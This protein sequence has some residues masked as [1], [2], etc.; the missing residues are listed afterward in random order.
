M[1]VKLESS[2]EYTSNQHRKT[3]CKQNGLMSCHRFDWG[4]ESSEFRDVLGVAM[5]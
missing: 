2:S 4:K 5:T 3:K 1:L